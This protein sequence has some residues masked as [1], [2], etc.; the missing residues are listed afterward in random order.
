MYFLGCFIILLT[1]IFDVMFQVTV[2]AIVIKSQLI[3]LFFCYIVFRRSFKYM[4][5][6]LLVYMFML[7]PFTNVKIIPLF[8]SY[9]LVLS[10]FYYLRIQLFSESYI[11]Q[12]FWVCVIYCLQ[13]FL[14]VIFVVNTWELKAISVFFITTLLNALLLVLF[15]LPCFMLWDKWF[16]FF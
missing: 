6:L 5:I 7:A 13:Q 3:A 16:D 9:F 4:M 2:G 8:L 14:R 15:A 1:L 12:S 11:I 10:L